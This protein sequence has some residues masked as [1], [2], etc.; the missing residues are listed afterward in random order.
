M[1]HAFIFFKLC[2][3]KNK[4]HKSGWRKSIKFF[5]ITNVYLFFDLHE[6]QQYIKLRKKLLSAL[7]SLIVKGEIYKVLDIKKK[8]LEKKS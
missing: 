8:Y 7:S 1:T 4:Y 2:K 6:F 5:P 3:S